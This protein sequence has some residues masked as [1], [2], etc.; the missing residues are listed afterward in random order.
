MLH[1]GRIVWE[2]PTE[3]LDCSGHP[4]VEQFVEGRA[5]GSVA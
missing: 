1:E 5:D 3:E 4:V 2:G